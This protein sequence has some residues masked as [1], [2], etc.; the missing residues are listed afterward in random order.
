MSR[1]LG[2]IQRRTLEYLSSIDPWAATAREVAQH[3]YGENW[4]LEFTDSKYQHA[5]TA[6]RTL[7]ARA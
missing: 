3:V 1:G 6:L 2:K 7:L 5:A 4:D